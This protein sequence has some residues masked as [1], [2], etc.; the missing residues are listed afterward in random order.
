MP[1][2]DDLSSE[3]IDLFF[4]F[5][6]LFYYVLSLFTLKSVLSTRAGL[7]AFWGRYLTQKRQILNFLL[8][9]NRIYLVF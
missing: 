7:I 3:A 9:R 1:I 6:S 4:F 2:F 8:G 5:P